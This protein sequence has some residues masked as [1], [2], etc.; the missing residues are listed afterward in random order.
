M[1]L[2]LVLLVALAA[3]PA[4]FAD[5][6]PAPAAVAACKAKAA[7]LGKEA[8]LAR[9]GATEPLGHC[10]SAHAAPT[11]RSG[12]D[13]PAVARCGAELAKLGAKGFIARYRT[14]DGCLHRGAPK[15]TKH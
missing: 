1:R 6:R 14:I 2:L 11:V 4:A 5:G 8:F 12:L 3:V 7:Q 9:Y 13:D 10:V 15:K